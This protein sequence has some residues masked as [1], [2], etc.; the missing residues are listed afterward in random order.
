MSI[1]NPSFEDEG[2]VLGV[3][4][5]W[6]IDDN[7]AHVEVAE[8]G[9]LLGFERFEQDWRLPYG[10]FIPNGNLITPVYWATILNG[11][12][13]IGSPLPSDFVIHPA[14]TVVSGFV[15][16]GGVTV[17]MTYVNSVDDTGRTAQVFIPEGVGPGTERVFLL[18]DEDIGFKEILSLST[19]PALPG[20]ELAVVG[21]WFLYP[22][23]QASK[24]AF[25]DD[26]GVDVFPFSISGNPFES[27]E[28]GWDNDGGF[29]NN[30]DALLNANA[31]FDV[32]QGRNEDSENF[33]DGWKLPQDPY[34]APFNE[35]LRVAHH[36]WIDGRAVTVAP[37]TF[38]VA[39]EAGDRIRFEILPDG[40]DTPLEIQLPPGEYTPAAMA[41]LLESEMGSALDADAGL[42]DNSHISVIALPDGTL[43]ITTSYTAAGPDRGVLRLLEP[44]TDSAWEE[45]G[46][47]TGLFSDRSPES[48][49]LETSA[50][51]PEDFEADWK[52]NQSSI[53]SLPD[54]ANGVIAAADF[55]G[56]SPN[57]PETFESGWVLTLP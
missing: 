6:E 54:D 56:P 34:L 50:V 25:S 43:R 52:D 20:V 13:V 10:A 40:T 45:L 3:P 49:T 44:I 30:F 37:F 26:P 8:F 11:T 24:F 19:T 55:G 5:G 39:E 27:F 36:P 9:P 42:A 15:P 7:T 47:I 31:V 53:F 4:A 29:R 23:N 35:V 2:S 32:L 14:V 16:G 46:F 22:R 1:Q 51:S 12:P 48:E 41:A 57:T 21:S 38:T 28:A 17:E 18:E 33:E